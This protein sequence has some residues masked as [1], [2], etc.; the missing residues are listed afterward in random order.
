MK[1]ILSILLLIVSFQTSTKAYDVVVAKDGSGNFKS[2]QEAIL[3]IRDYTPIPRTIFIKNGVYTEK[4][5]IPENKCNITIIGESKDSTVLT[6]DDH[7]KINNMGTF[8]TYTLKVQGN[9]IIIR[10]ITVENNAPQLG[11]AVA[12]HVEGTKFRMLNCKLLGNQD[13]LFTGNEFGKQYYKNCYI[14]GTTDFIFGPA[15]AW[16]ENCEI[17]SKKNSYITAASTPQNN[18]YGYIFNNCKLTANS[19]ATKVYLGRPWRSYANVLF[20]NCFMDKHI[21]PEGWHNWRDP[22]KEKTAR[23]AEY[24]NMGEGANR[25]NRVA[26]S[27]ELNKKLAKKFILK[28]VFNDWPEVDQ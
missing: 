22:E 19:D 23:Y 17:K 21:H 7:A 8:N 14:E 13:T 6:Y 11:Q 18:T 26:W 9:N 4:V 25:S 1:Y 27:K 12:L 16:F 5:V 24:N 15:T 28:K 3:S 10:N 2:I 20:M